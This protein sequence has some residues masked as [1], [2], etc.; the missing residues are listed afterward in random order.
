M[1]PTVPLGTGVIM[2]ISGTGNCSFGGDGSLATNSRVDQPYDVWVDSNGKIFIADYGN[3][4]IRA[5]LTDGNMATL[6]GSNVTG[7]NGD[8]KAATLSWLNNP[9]S[10]G[11]DSLGNIYI[12]D[13]YNQR[14]R[15]VSTGG[16]MT[17]IAGTGTSGYDGDGPGTAGLVNFP[18]G[19]FVSSNGYLYFADTDN[20]MVRMINLS[21]GWLSRIAGTGSVG[22]SGD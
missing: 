7:Y 11:G 17:T 15:K 22:S 1:N 21:S 9:R 4:R 12:S 10:V 20:Q 3:S 16:I 19:L 18:G 13:T 8:E 2:T 14:I 5:I 6:A